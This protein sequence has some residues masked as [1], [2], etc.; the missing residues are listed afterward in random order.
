MIKLWNQESVD[1]RLELQ[2]KGEGDSLPLRMGD[3]PRQLLVELGEA[4]T[5]EVLRRAAAK[6]VKTA[7]EYGAE[8]ALLEAPAAQDA[9][10]LSAMALGAALARYRQESWKERKDKPF[11]LY[12]A[13]PAGVDGEQALAESAALAKAVCF[14]RDL[15]NCPANKLTPMDMARRM[16]EAAQKLGVETQVLDEDQTRA[17]GMEAFL[18]VGTSALHPARLIVLRYKG[19]K[20]DQAPVALVG[21]GVTC[22][23]GGYCLKTAAGLKGTRGDM[24]G[25]AAVCGAILALAEN[26]VPVNAVAVI[27]A[28]ENRL[29][30]DSF[31]PGDVIGSMSGKTIEVGNT[32]AE[33]RLI[34]ADAV[35]YAL[36]KEGAAKVV[37]IA[38]LTGAVVQALGFTTA[39]LLTNNE[40]FY[41]SLQAA[42][43]RC[44]EQYWRLPTFP[45]Y[46]KMIESPVADISNMSSD[47]CGAITAGLFVGAFAGDTP[48]IHLDIAGTAWVDSP[49]RE[50]QAKGATGAGVAT[51]YELCKGFA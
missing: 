8:S 44:G 48:W 7:C 39:G 41:A 47:G 5:P 34:L 24:A 32:D 35:T 23:T 3:Q 9:G 12:I 51:L 45:E 13:C 10:A 1:W 50:Y 49:R 16:T 11:T 6:A 26:H 33:G 38:T 30:P 21:K 18:T 17:L 37:D 25:A 20:P 14:A 4:V 36:E 22:D 42:A 31:I 27:P 15:V 40:E 19:G 2:A 29:S 28:V 46:K 43:D